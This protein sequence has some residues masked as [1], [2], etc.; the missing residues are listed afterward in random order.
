MGL[1]EAVGEGPAGV[2]TCAF[3]YFIEEHP[4]FLPVVAPL[5]EAADRQRLRIV[6]SSVTLLEVL[7]VP[8][9]AGD[10]ALAARY[11]SLLTG[12]RGVSMV[13]ID[14]DQIHLAA[15]VRARHRVR[16]PDALQ[17]SA[18]LSRRCT[19]FVTNDRTLPALT[20]LRII[21]LSEYVTP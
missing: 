8:L 15:Y 14:R 6:T 12:S 13:E 7:V 20:D 17:L 2:D 3:I 11:E 19:V 1:I 4:R 10:S 16:T 18:A 9:A 5:F 21:Q